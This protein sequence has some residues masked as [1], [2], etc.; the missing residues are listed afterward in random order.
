MLLACALKLKLENKQLDF[1]S[2][3]KFMIKAWDFLVNL[4]Y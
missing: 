4:K 3:V 2:V 1:S